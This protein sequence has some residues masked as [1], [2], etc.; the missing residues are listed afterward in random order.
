[1][2]TQEIAGEMIADI[3]EAL[4]LLPVA[5]EERRQRIIRGLES[6]SRVFADYI[7]GLTPIQLEKATQGMVK[8]LQTI[9]HYAGVNDEIRLIAVHTRDRF[10]QRIEFAKNNNK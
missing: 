7:S 5:H 1:V 10:L 3:E 4:K 6:C 8:N 2:P 9:E